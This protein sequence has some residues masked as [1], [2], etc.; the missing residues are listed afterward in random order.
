LAEH[1]ARLRA[2]TTV[3]PARRL[4]DGRHRPPARRPIALSRFRRLLVSAAIASLPP[5]GAAAGQFAL[6]T[7]LPWRTVETPHF[8]FHYPTDLE[9]W[10][11]AVAE[12]MESI[13]SAVTRLVGYQPTRKTQIVIDDPYAIG[14]GSAW[15]FLD[16]PIINFWA[17]PPDPREEVGN[18]RT[19]GEILGTHE[20]AHIAHL[21]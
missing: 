20:F 1:A 9:E 18:Y 6:R 10:T 8:A 17:T 14:N 11:L 5:H 15:P 13:D 7:W 2:H 3:H 21:T 12:R 4:V 16:R 19:W